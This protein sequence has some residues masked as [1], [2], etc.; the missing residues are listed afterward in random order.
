MYKRF[1][2]LLFLM[3]AGFLY[4]AATGTLFSIF[5]WTLGFFLL[6]VAL[7]V[8]LYVRKEKQGFGPD[9]RKDG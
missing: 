5:C 2:L 4:G 6:G 9:I 3:A 1:F 7:S 8:F